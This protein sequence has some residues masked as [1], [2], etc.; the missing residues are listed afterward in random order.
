MLKLI[1][2]LAPD[3]HLLLNYS[4]TNPTNPT[5]LR[6]PAMT[7]CLRLHTTR[8]AKWT[9]NAPIKSSSIHCVVVLVVVDTSLDHGTN[10][11]TNSKD[12]NGACDKGT[13]HATR[14]QEFTWRRQITTVVKTTHA[15]SSTNDTKA[16]VNRPNTTKKRV[17]TNTSARRGS[18]QD[19][20][21][22]YRGKALNTDEP[23]ARICAATEQIAATQCLQENPF[24][25]PRGA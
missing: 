9:T 1:S 15:V 6:H 16:L 7:D 17:K 20:R 24:Q 3:V 19:A 4:A 14:S 25:N 2:G 18:G 11:D 12:V 23:L 10:G 13:H 5:S 21:S 8:G 22:M